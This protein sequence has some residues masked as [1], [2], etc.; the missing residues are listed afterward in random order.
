MAELVGFVSAIVGLIQLTGTLTSISYGYI[1]GVK[2]APKDI[3]R[4]V[5][6]LGLLGKVLISL[7]G[8]AD[9]N[10]SSK[11]LERLNDEDGP[12]QACLMEFR[13]LE[14]KLQPSGGVK[15]VIDRLKWPLKES[16]T[17]ACIQRIEAK[18]LI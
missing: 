8:Y 15:G 13:E 14:S 5:S 17:Q 4:L 6:E 7:K 1:G 16:D 11:A 3:T 12:L 10:P 18:N 9:E 2:H